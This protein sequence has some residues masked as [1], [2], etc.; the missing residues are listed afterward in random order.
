[1]TLLKDRKQIADT[2]LVI[3]HS[4]VLLTLSHTEPVTWIKINNL[5]KNMVAIFITNVGVIK[6]GRIMNTLDGQSSQQSRVIG[7]ILED[8]LLLRKRCKSPKLKLHKYRT[9]TFVLGTSEK[10]WKPFFTVSPVCINCRM[11]FTP[12]S[13][14]FLGYLNRHMD[15][16]PC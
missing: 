10:T 11:L 3:F 8:K 9:K 14:V 7:L 16:I 6:F 4:V 15:F 12:N 5:D 2:S 1:M 13:T